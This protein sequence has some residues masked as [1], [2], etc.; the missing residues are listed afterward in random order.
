MTKLKELGPIQYRTEYV[1]QDGSVKTVLSD[2][3]D[4]E[5]SNTRIVRYRVDGSIEY[6]IYCPYIPDDLL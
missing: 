6:I 5:N 4:P 3:F 2:G 1:Q